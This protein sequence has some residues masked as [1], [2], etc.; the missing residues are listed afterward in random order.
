METRVGDIVIPQEEQTPDGF[1][2]ALA[3]AQRHAKRMRAE[4]GKA[5]GSLDELDKIVETASETTLFEEDYHGYA[6]AAS[7]AL[8]QATEDSN[9]ALSHGGEAGN[10]I[11]SVLRVFMGRRW[12]EVRANRD[13]KTTQLNTIRQ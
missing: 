5:L 4:L 9:R 12:R 2:Q 6:K 8:W 1:S 3:E 7:D 10:H 13:K 11:F